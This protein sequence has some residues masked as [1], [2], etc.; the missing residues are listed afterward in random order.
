[1]SIASECLG[2]RERER[3]RE[4]HR[5]RNE[6]CTFGTIGLQ[7]Y[8]MKADDLFKEDLVFSLCFFKQLLVKRE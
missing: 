1:M 6:K 4:S 2:E 7:K 5:S 3:E 8:F